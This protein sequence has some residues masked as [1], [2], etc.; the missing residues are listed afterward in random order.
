ML[1]IGGPKGGGVGVWTPGKSQVLQVYI[2][3]ALDPNGKAWT[4]PKLEIFIITVFS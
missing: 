4:P 3:I 2:G 1:A